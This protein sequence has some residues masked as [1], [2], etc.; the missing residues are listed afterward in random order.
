MRTTIQEYRKRCDMNLMP[1]SKYDINSRV[2][3][4]VQEVN[5]YLAECERRAREMLGI[6]NDN[7]KEGQTK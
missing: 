7:N 1:I 2:E 3:L 4:I 5:E 6:D